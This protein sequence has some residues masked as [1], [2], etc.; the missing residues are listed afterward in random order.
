M[1]SEIN[2][3]ELVE[4][5]FE[6]TISDNPERTKCRWLQMCVLA[7]AMGSLL[8]GT[9]EAQHYKAVAQRLDEAV[10]NGELSSEQ[11]RIMMDALR[12]AGIC[13]RSRP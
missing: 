5:R 1:A 13:L 7:C 6:M 4:K 2:S 3:G 9:A 12:K 10:S 11:A 8:C